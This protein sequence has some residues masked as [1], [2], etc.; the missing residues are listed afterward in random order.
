MVTRQTGSVIFKTID[1][2]IQ[3]RNALQVS[4]ITNGSM[5]TTDEGTK[6]NAEPQ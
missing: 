6:T 1:K 3:I 5:E 4:D 2:M